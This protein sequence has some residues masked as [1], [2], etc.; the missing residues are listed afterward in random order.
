[1]I[2]FGNQR[3]LPEQCRERYAENSKKT[4]SPFQFQVPTANAVEQPQAY[5]RR[6][7][8]K[9]MSPQGHTLDWQ[10]VCHLTE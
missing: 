5:R 9:K 8:T 3:L 4:D 7:C 6:Q 1:L 2:G 10:Q